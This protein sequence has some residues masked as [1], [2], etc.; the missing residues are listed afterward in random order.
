MAH[1]TQRR[2]S[3][4]Y[5]YEQ[6][7]HKEKNTTH[8]AWPSLVLF[9][10]PGPAPNFENN[11]RIQASDWSKISIPR[12]TMKKFSSFFKTAGDHVWAAPA[13]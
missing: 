11:G 10:S 13:S 4:R 8:L 9:Y 6:N 5:E 1:T 12:G 2:H 3:H 7:T